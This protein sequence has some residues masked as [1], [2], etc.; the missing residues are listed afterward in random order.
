MHLGCIPSLSVPFPELVDTVAA[1]GLRH[2]HLGQRHFGDLSASQVRAEAR[3]AG[4]TISAMWAW[5]GTIKPGM[6]EPAEIEQG[7]AKLEDT[8]RFAQEIGCPLLC[9]GGGHPGGYTI[10]LNNRRPGLTEEVIDCW[11]RAVPLLEK[12]GIYLSVETGVHT[13]VY[14][15]DQFA[16]IFP[17][18]GSKY[19]S[20]NMDVVNMLSAEDYYDQHPKIDALFDRARGYVTSAHLKDIVHEPKLHTHLYE[21]VPGDGH[22]DWE[23]VLA[24]L[25][26]DL[27]AWG[28]GY[29]EATPWEAMP[30]AVEFLRAKAR[31]VGMPLD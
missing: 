16:E 10:N 26:R 21:A 22:L 13:T 7:L 8:L 11:R 2:V 5:A 4:V 28:A 1:V 15:P 9:T 24:H 17:R 6:K 25:S 12:Y 14:K 31:A 27:P 23:Y 20:L 3:R 29:I 19:F 18:V 30:R